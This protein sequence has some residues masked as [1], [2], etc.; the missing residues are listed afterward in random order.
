VARALLNRKAE[1]PASAPVAEDP[2]EVERRRLADMPVIDRLRLEAAKRDDEDRAIA[3]AA[4]AA[5]KRLNDEHE[6]RVRRQAEMVAGAQRNW[7]IHRDALKTKRD[8][9]F[10]ALAAK[11]GEVATLRQSGDIAGALEAARDIPTLK[12]WLAEVEAELAQWQR[13]QP[14]ALR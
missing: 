11:E 7:A 1:V 6:A 3:D 12:A 2:A 14:G 8:A 10:S 13:C 9:A 4:A 5:Q